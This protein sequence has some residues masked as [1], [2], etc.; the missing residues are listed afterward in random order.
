LMMMCRMMPGKIVDNV[1]CFR[2][3]INAKVFLVNEGQSHV[4]SLRAPL[5]DSAVH[6]IGNSGVVSGVP[7]WMVG[8]GPFQ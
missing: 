4:N 7:G 3:P 5:F 6:D 8:D 1:D 2:D